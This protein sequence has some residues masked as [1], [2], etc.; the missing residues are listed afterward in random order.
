[1]KR[2]ESRG[3][4]DALKARLVRARAAAAERKADMVRS[5]MAIRNAEDR[6][7]ALV[8][9]PDLVRTSGIEYIAETEPLAGEVT[10][11]AAQSAI[12]A[13][14]NRPEIDQGFGQLTALAHRQNMAKN[15]LLP[16]LNLIVE[17]TL[18]GLAKD[19][20]VDE[21]LGTEL[22][23]IGY[24]V[25]LSFEYPFGNNAARARYL[26]R[27]LEV[28]QQMS[29]IQTTLHTVMLEV[30]IAVREVRTAFREMQAKYGALRAAEEDVRTA[31]ERWGLDAVAAGRGGSAY[32]DFL[33]DAQGRRTLAE[34]EYLRSLVAYNLALVNL[35]RTKGTLLRYEEIQVQRDAEDGLP[36]IR[37]ELGGAAA[38]SGVGKTGE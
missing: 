6:I 7:K 37:L 24:L 25:G 16:Q 35:E 8:N 18:N 29:Q 1:V 9:A 13:L 3:D 38:K 31:E 19:T 10:I 20:N 32:L 4:I 5:E 14:K 26:R 23:H 30:K 28:R 2:I 11:D 21:A 33:L 27:K 36:V 12:S 34:H 17:C 22:D 15:E